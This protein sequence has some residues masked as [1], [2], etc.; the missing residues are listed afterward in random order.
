M[1]CLRQARLQFSQQHLARFD[2]VVMELVRP[3]RAGIVDID[4]DI[5]GLQRVEDDGGAEAFARGGGEARRLQS[6]RDQRRQNILLG[7]GLGADDVGRWRAR[8]SRP[9]CGNDDA[10]PTPP[11]DR[12]NA[13]RWRNPRSI[14]ASN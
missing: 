12:A 10:M 5:A 1:F 7:E 13:L 14:S 2:I 3:Q 8:H 4:I 9:A 11:N 6:L